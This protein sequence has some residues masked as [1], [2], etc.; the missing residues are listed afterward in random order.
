MALAKFIKADTENIAVYGGNGLYRPFWR[1]RFELLI[2]I[3][4][5][6]DNAMSEGI[7]KFGIAEGLFVRLDVFG[8][9]KVYVRGGVARLGTKLVFVQTL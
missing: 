9:D 5:I 4:G 3:S 8:N 7:D 1:E 6:I 2:K